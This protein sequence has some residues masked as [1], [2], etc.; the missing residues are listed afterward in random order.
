MALRLNRYCLLLLAASTFVD[1]APRKVAEL[2]ISETGAT[3]DPETA[4][5]CKGFRPTAPQIKRYFLRAYPVESYVITTERYSPCYASG[6]IKFSDNNMGEWW[7]FSGGTATIKWNRGG[8]VD[9]L[10]KQKN[11]WR[12]PFAGGYGLCDKEEC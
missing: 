7:L 3:V 6:K 10:Y 1:A 11:G 9:L 12:D 5:M 4:E 8:S 2:T